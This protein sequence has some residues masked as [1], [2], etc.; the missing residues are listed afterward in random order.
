MTSHTPLSHDQVHDLA[1]HLT[2]IK[3]YVQLA[4]RTASH[5]DALPPLPDYLAKALREIDALVLMVTTPQA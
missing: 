3:G 5:V 4:Q 1:T 2:A